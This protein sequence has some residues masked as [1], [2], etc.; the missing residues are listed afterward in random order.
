M[1]HIKSTP[2]V[3]LINDYISRN[4]HE[5]NFRTHN[6]PTKIK[7]CP[8]NTPEKKFWT[9][10]IPTRKNFGP[11]KY[12]REKILDSQNTHEKKVWTHEG[13]VNETQETRNDT[14]LTRF[15][16]FFALQDSYC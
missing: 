15:S 2:K 9:H 3:F 6:I 5:K 8:R 7:L 1:L 4:T 16:I 14:R 11:T 12:S 13:T 10:K